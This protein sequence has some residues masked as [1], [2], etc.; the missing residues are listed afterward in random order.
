MTDEVIEM[1]G[2]TPTRQDMIVNDMFTLMTHQFSELFDKAPAGYLSAN[3]IEDVIDGMNSVLTQ[4]MGEGPVNADVAFQLNRLH[5]EGRDWEVAYHADKKQF[6]AV[7]HTPVG[8]VEHT[9]SDSLFEAIREARKQ[10]VKE[11]VNGK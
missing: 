6:V 5:A 8:G 10:L 11:P 1:S 2:N 9:K 4:H 3:R 7:A